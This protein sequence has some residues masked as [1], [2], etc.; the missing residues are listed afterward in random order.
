MK[1]LYL[2]PKTLCTTIL[3]SKKKK[4]NGNA[5]LFISRFVTYQQFYCYSHCSSELKNLLFIL[6]TFR[7]FN[8]T[9]KFYK[10]IYLN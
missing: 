6:N 9:H 1:F 4:D 2:Y 7:K 3:Q 8:Y 10:K 5:K